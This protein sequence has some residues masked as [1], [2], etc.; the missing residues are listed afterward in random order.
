[1]PRPRV[2]DDAVRTRL[3]EVASE[4]VST[5]GPEALAL[6]DVAARAGTS[7]TAVYSLFGGRPQLV[8]AVGDEAFRRFAAHLGGVPRTGDPETDLAALGHA[9]RDSALAD[10]HF[11]RVM[12]DVEGTGARAAQAPPVHSHA[13]FAVLR[14]AVRAVVGP[15]PDGDAV[16]RA[17]HA[18]WALAHGL[19][20]LELAGLTPGDGDERAAQFATALRSAGPALVA[21]A[22]GAGPPGPG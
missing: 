13:T 20:S 1:M 19:V 21:A 14:D 17:A 6:R 9:Y 2:H 5:R 16:E 11:Y 7:T 18:L 15:E 12:F 22:L 4:V 8:A 10:P 3:L